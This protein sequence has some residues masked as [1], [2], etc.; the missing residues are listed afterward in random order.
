MQFKT[1]DA[2]YAE[3]CLGILGNSADAVAEKLGYL[4]VTGNRQSSNTCPIANFLKDVGFGFVSVGPYTASVQ[5]DDGDLSM[6]D[7]VTLP[8]PVR[9]FIAKFDDRQYPDLERKI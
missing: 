7:G 3:T 5:W 6:T 2:E 8:A 9:E 4:E 1:T